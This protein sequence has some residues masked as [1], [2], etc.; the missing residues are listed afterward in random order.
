M[1][2]ITVFLLAFFTTTVW[3]QAVCKYSSDG[4]LP[5]SDSDLVTSMTT[6]KV[7]VRSRSGGE[8]KDCSDAKVS[9]DSYYKE[10]CLKAAAPKL[11]PQFCA[12]KSRCFNKATSNNGY[13]CY[14]GKAGTEIAEE[15]TTCTATTADSEILSCDV[16]NSITCDVAEPQI[17]EELAA[18][19][20]H[21]IQ[22][23]EIEFDEYAKSSKEREELKKNLKRQCRGKA[24][25][26]K[27][28]LLKHLTQDKK[29]GQALKVLFKRKK[30]STKSSSTSK[31]NR[32]QTVAIDADNFENMTD[33]ELSKFAIAQLEKQYPGLQQQ[34]IDLMNNDPKY[35]YGFHVQES[36]PV[37]IV[38]NRNGKAPCHI[39]LADFPTDEPFTPYE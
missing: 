30:Y 27:K 35:R 10:D 34:S 38:L 37:N 8:A 15:N 32:N 33:D 23:G 24:K 12:S 39:N 13:Y 14:C 20:D 9:G 29:Y 7:K 5:I 3:S 36:V 16:Q 26:Y 22:C 19:S 6:N 25:E 28:A 4:V 11:C 1:K 31:E 2:I 18:T 21:A 17:A